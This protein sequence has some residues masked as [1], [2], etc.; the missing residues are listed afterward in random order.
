MSDEELDGDEE[1]ATGTGVGTTC[2]HDTLPYNIDPRENL[3]LIS[4][5][6]IPTWLLDPALFPGDD[7][8]GNGCLRTLETQIGVQ[9]HSNLWLYIG[10]TATTIHH[11]IRLEGQCN[12]AH[13]E[14]LEYGGR[15]YNHVIQ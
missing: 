9:I 2:A 6:V 1:S 14:C 15:L 10:I 8:A 3:I 12:E 11:E 13:I 5:L 7:G 4:P